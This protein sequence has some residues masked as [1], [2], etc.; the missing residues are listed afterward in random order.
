[1]NDRQTPNSQSPTPEE[2]TL[3]DRAIEATKN[4]VADPEI[5]H[6]AASRVLQRLTA[7]VAASTAGGAA[8]TGSIHGCEGF[9]ELM[10]ALL[11]GALTES[12]R[13]LLE[14]HTREC[15]NCRRELQR[16]RRGEPVGGKAAVVSLESRRARFAVPR[17]ALAAGISALLVAGFAASRFLPWG[18]VDARV[19][20]IQGELFDD[21]NRAIVA[22]ATLGR[23]D[24]VRTARNSGAVLE[25][26]D[27]SRFELAERSELRLGRRRDG[28]MVDLSRGGLI[29]EA[30]RQSGGDHLYVKT[31]DVTVAVTGTVFSVNHGI[32]GSRVSVLDGEVRVSQ[33]G[34][35]D[36][37]GD[38]SGFVPAVLRPGDQYVSRADLAR[39]PLDRD[40]SWS[41]DAAR[42]RREIAALKTVGRE[43]DQALASPLRTSTRLLDLAPAGTAVYLAAPNVGPSLGG[44]WDR[45]KDQA[46]SNP[47][48]ASWWNRQ[49]GPHEA[50][51]EELI[52]EL[53][54]IGA[55][56]GAEVAVAIDA[57]GGNE[58]PLI[59]AEVPNPQAFSPILDE[60]IARFNQRMD[61]TDGERHPRLRRVTGVP[62]AAADDEV[63][64]WL[65]G[66]LLLIA[67][68]PA[69]LAAVD[70]SAN[71]SN[72][73]VGT[74]FHARIAAIY[75]EG[76]G[77]VGAIDAHR[78]ATDGQH[79]VGD[80]QAFE[81][82]GLADVEAVVF[83]ATSS[84]AGGSTRALVSFSGARRGIAS[85]LAAPASSGALEFVSPD[86]HLAFGALLK[87]PVDMFDDLIGMT[88]NQSASATEA[89]A[90]F[91]RE[92]GV[93]LREDLAAALGGDV[94]FAFDGPWLPQPTWKLVVEVVDQAGLQ[95]T[96]E[97][98]V[99]E[100][101]ASATE[102]VRLV[103][104]QEAVGNRPVY[105]LEAVAADTGATRV[106]AFYLYED[107][108]LV[109]GPNRALLLEAITQRNAGITLQS[110]QRFNELLPSDGHVHFSAVVYQD[111][112]AVSGLLGQWLGAAQ[113]MS[114][115]QRKEIE[116]LAQGTASLMV[117][118][119]E[120]NAIEIAG[121]TTDG[122]F[123]MGFQKLLGLTGMTRS[124]EE[125]AS[126]ARARGAAQEAPA[127]SRRPTA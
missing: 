23:G 59:L 21:G 36:R 121:R 69:P 99:T 31:G 27:G 116:N 125:R 56:L 84:D 73:F 91:E 47:A 37:S 38:G 89:M 16:L 43:I 67:T 86:A 17:W 104:T 32:K 120:E 70:A 105:R 57:M 93:A 108:Y 79:P 111:L 41:R 83:N 110:A 61:T 28:V 8:G 75:A 39:V 126:G 88:Q 44:A 127:S 24:V 97:R 60:K 50:E 103:L 107:G 78:Y 76:A 123:G 10:P 112:G 106:T 48:F 15:V 63:L 64:I 12:R 113:G 52:S 45:L 22:G 18:S 14:D 82:S 66:D 49:V 114:A 109:A 53:R 122:P 101:N 92:H 13:I 87:R 117:A 55:G 80:R 124:E 25:L 90:K 68:A 42:Y 118:Y 40:V 74:P 62:A 11:S 98:L 65:R 51:I 9:V 72:P 95:S 115:E 7:E 81:A 5:A 100:W 77:W 4:E 2:S 26:A 33:S 35:S 46:A 19:A 102:N 96:L 6:A 1:M 94:A 85:W 29:V 34:R 3:L 30:A 20:S 71:G 54:E 119:G 58:S